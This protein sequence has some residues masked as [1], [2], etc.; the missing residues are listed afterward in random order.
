MFRLAIAC[1]VIALVAAGLGYGGIAGSFAGAAKVLFMVFVA[2]AAVMAIVGCVVRWKA[3]AG[4]L[5]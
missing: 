3:S 1:F 4:R 5:A 2:I